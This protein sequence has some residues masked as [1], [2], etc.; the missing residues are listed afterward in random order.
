MDDDSGPPAACACK[1]F[2]YAWKVDDYYFAVHVVDHAKPMPSEALRVVAHLINGVLSTLVAPVAPAPAPAPASPP[3]VHPD[4]VVLHYLPVHKLIDLT[5]MK[6][7]GEHEG[8]GAG[9]VQH[10][11][12]VAE[13]KGIAPF[14]TCFRNLLATNTSADGL[15]LAGKSMVEIRYDDVA[16]LATSRF[17]IIEHDFSRVSHWPL[18]QLLV[19]R[20]VSVGL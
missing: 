13:T 6:G 16:D 5:L 20:C 8:S 15:F 10:L 12:T 9:A 7:D 14:L 3:L 19:D 18:L 4:T 17:A 11:K 1:S 2:V